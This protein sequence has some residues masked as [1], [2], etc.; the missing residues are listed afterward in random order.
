VGAD[1]EVAA[2]AFFLDFFFVFL[3]TFLSF[4]V[5]F[6]SFPDVCSA[7]AVAGAGA[8]STALTVRG[9]KAIAADARAIVLRR[10]IR[11]I[12][13]TPVVLQII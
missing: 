2:L 10:A 12:I 5:F 7:G 4:L 6:K 13:N 8:G 1:V 9:D 3:S 11:E